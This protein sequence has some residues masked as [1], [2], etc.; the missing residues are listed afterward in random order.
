M[1]TY[2]FIMELIGTVAFAISGAAQAIRVKMDIFGVAVM[3]LVTAVGGGSTKITVKS[4]NGITLFTMPVTVHSNKI[5]AYAA[6][7]ASGTK[8]S[9]SK[10]DGAA[11]YRV[12]KTVYSGGKWGK[13]KLYKTT[14]ALSCID[15]V[16]KSGQKVK[17]SVYG[18]KNGK[19]VGTH[20]T[21][22]NTH[23]CNPTVTA[24]STSKG[25]K[26]TWT[27]VTGATYYTV[28]RSIYSNG[29]W[30]AYTTVK[31]TKSLSFTDTKI[32]AGQKA[33]YAV[34]AHNGSYE[35]IQSVCT[36]TYLKQPTV[37]L[38]KA[39]K[40][41]K[42]SWGKISG[43]GTY[44]IYKSVYKNGKWSSYS[45]YKTTKST[46]YTDT[47]VKK[48]QKVRYTVYAVCSSCKKGKSATKTGVSITR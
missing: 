43:A 9:W 37:K 32:K 34:A 11:Y 28:K 14:K 39:T 31:T 44:Q 47:S 4:K 18:Y 10:V 2:I 15:D 33:H 22:T 36:A 19:K 45:H 41:V 46:A 42:I 24:T 25:E 6:A 40:G 7:T 5:H 1:K 48:G 29:K 30:S 12:Y 13:A 8:I 26:I 23:L 21:I 16:H 3:G 20:A 38:A 35:S 27:K 17:Y